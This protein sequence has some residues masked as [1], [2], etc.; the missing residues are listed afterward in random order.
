MTRKPSTILLVEDDPAHAMLVKRSFETHRQPNQIFHVP[1]GEAALNYLLQQD[2]YQ[3]S[4]RPDLV[5]LDLRL[6]KID[7]LQVLEKIKSTDVIRTIPVVI[8]SSSSSERD[9]AAA[10]SR[11]ANS[12]LVKPIDFQSFNELMGELGVY[13]LRW[14]CHLKN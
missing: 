12:Y 4:V 7:G 8:L 9:I 1:D 5:L 13:W 10:Y 11:H 3:N 6:P 2:G 14:N